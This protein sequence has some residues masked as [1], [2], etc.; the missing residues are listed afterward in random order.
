MPTDLMTTETPTMPRGRSEFCERG[1]HDLCGR[2]LT[3]V[4]FRDAIILDSLDYNDG[5]FLHRALRK[6][7][8]V[9]IGQIPNYALDTYLAPEGM[10]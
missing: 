7:R 4:E 1:I 9:Y 2:S 5:V 10:P 6:G 3:D 8:V